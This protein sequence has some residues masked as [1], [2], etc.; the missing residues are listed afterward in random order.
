M[1]RT[2]TLPELADKIAASTGISHAESEAF[3]K[4]LFVLVAERLSEGDD[5]TVKG[6]GRFAVIEDRVE[7]CP[8]AEFAEGVNMP[9]AAFEAI[10]LGDDITPEMLDAV[11]QQPD[12]VSEPETEPELEPVQEIE[13]A[14]EPELEAVIE[15]PT[16]IEEE[17]VMEE[18]PV[19][20]L[21]EP[22]DEPATEPVEIAEPESSEPEPTELSDE[23]EVV[24]TE[25]G[26][27][28]PWWNRALWIIL[29]ILWGV[30]CYF[31][32][33]MTAPIVTIYGPDSN[34]SVD[35]TDDD[36]AAAVEEMSQAL[37]AA[38][39]PA[40]TM[41]DTVA[42]PPV[43]EQ[44]P[45]PE[46]ASASVTDTVRRNRYLTTMAR[47]HYGLMDFWVYIYEEN[48]DHLGDPNKIK[49][50]TTVVIPPASKYGIDRNDPESVRK[51]KLK[52]SEIYAPYQK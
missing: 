6:L 50:G 2:I 32:G 41:I 14:S 18:A 1:N 15:A 13:S 30:L 4:D 38:A 27:H 47:E 36:M 37:E 39:V 12:I 26:E 17:I 23:P 16:E 11:S 8:D 5:V 20:E 46:P 24:E 7:F 25:A 45:E 34:Y 42:V 44:T 35:L 10:E 19:E 52:A 3:V 31:V 40:D 51:A 21:V 28:S 9:F 43:V 49:P 22:V 48:A 33:Y 29:F